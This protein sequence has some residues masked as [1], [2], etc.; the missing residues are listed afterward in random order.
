MT[1]K[2]SKLFEAA[3][4]EIP[5]APS[6]RPRGNTSRILRGDLDEIVLKALRKEPQRRYA[7]VEQ[8]AEDIRRHLDGLPVVARRYST[9]YR[10]TKFVV[11]HKL[12]VAAG[13]VVL[14]AIAGGVAATV[15]EA[16]IAAENGRR[17]ERRFQ[18][19]RTLANSLMFEIH[20]SVDGLPGSTAARKLIVQRSLEYLD[21]LSQESNGDVSLQRELANAYERIGM[22]QG[23]PSGANVGDISGAQKSLAKALTIR[24]KISQAESEPNV[25]DALA[26]ASSY[27]EMCAINARYLGHI[28]TALGY[29]SQAVTELEELYKHRPDDQAVVLELAMAYESTGKVYGE[30]S[31]SGNAGDSYKALDNHQKALAL[32]SAISHQHPEDL[33]LT[34]RQGALSLL[35]ADD[36]FEIGKVSEA[37]P[38]YRR[39]TETL[40]RVTRQSNKMTYLDTL[41]FAYQRMG[42]MQLVAGRFTDAVPIYRKQLETSIR[43]AGEDP[44]SMTFRT[45]LAASRATYG[46]A[47]WRAGRIEEGLASFRLGLAELEETKQQD[48]R[49]TGLESTLRL[50]MAGALEKAGDIDGAMRDYRLANDYYAHICETDPKDQEDC[51][52]LSGTED[53]IARI[54]LRQGKADAALD[55]YQKGLSMTEASSLGDKPNLEAVYTVMNVYYGL[56]EADARLA[57]ESPSEAKRAD[58]QKQS[59][60]WYQKSEA[61]FHRIPEWLP[62]TPNEFDSRTPREIEARLASCRT[63]TTDIAAVRK[64]E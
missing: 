2:P 13:V 40:E 28:G 3:L 23:D 6:Q 59:C 27:R 7:S 22:V 55:L 26:L 47:L 39:A 32:V 14:L 51:L 10:V 61:A 52:S 16:Q 44:K 34:S 33:D 43:L 36:L 58:L 8:M 15:R 41:A 46:N 9:W 62:I 57:K 31:T 1:R 60:A 38:L 63:S 21:R 5:E 24:Q 42:D 48:S 35:T 17:A 45:S 50:W 20:D 49:A 4:Q 25:G 18:D 56:G 12:G 54:L 53:R 29:C 37:V 30:G 19:V 64:P 11:R